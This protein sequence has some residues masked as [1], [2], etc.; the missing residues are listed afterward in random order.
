MRCIGVLCAYLCCG[1]GGREGGAPVHVDECVC[2]C[3]QVRETD[4]NTGQQSIPK[5]T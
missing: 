2:V 4:R 1:G 3:D 5:H